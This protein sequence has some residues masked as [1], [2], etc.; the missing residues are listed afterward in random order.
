MLVQEPKLL[1]R[2]P[3]RHNALRIDSDPAYLSLKLREL[4]MRAYRA[5][6]SREGARLGDGVA[7]DGPVLDVSPAEDWADLHS[8]IVQLQRAFD[9]QHMDSLAAYVGALRAQVESALV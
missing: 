9:A 7:E 2:K 3:V 6:R 5:V 4:A 1:P 8:E